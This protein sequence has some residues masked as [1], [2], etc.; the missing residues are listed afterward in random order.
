MGYLAGLPGSLCIARTRKLQVRCN[1][2]VTDATVSV[3]SSIGARFSLSLF[4][5]LPHSTSYPPPH[6][7]RCATTPLIS[8]SPLELHS[9]F[10]SLLLNAMYPDFLSA[11][12]ISDHL[13]PAAP[14]L[15]DNMDD[16][17][18]WDGPP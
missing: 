15:S 8:L 9:T 10:Y 4:H 3:A 13:E 16:Y 12:P 11:L 17:V 1:A 6:P 14:M 18:H 2:H 5:S 7:Q